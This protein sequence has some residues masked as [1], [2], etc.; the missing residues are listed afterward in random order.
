MK[1][2]QDLEA[3]KGNETE[4]KNF[5]LSAITEYINSDDYKIATESELYYKNRNPEIE[6]TE[7]IVYDLNGL[8]HKDEFSPNS[9]IKQNYYFILINQAVMYTL[10]NGIAFDNEATKEKLG[11]DALDSVTR[12]ILTD[13]MISKVG[14]VYFYYCFSNFFI[15][16]RKC[17]YTSLIL[18]L[19]WIL[20]FYFI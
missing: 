13:A 10:G 17:R 9:K 14:W 3:V 6:A 1:T 8:A 5:I 12:K 20:F 16:M 11:G 15:I 18:T 2:Y 19:I 4:L 7:K